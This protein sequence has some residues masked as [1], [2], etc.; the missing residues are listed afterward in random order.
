MR[1]KIKHWFTLVEI[2][3]VVS[4]LSILSTIAFVN[5]SSYTVWSRDFK[6]LWDI[7]SIKSSL[8]TYTKNNLWQ[9]P[10]VSSVSLWLDINS[11]A[12]NLAKQSYFDEEIAWKIGITKL[13]IDPKTNNRYI[14]SVTS[15]KTRY[16]ITATLEDR[17]TKIAFS[18]NTYAA[19]CTDSQKAY[20][21]WNY[22]YQSWSNLPG[23]IYAV[24]MTNPRII[25]DIN[26]NSWKVVLNWQ[27]LNVAYDMNSTPQSCATNLNQ[28]ILASTTIKGTQN[29]L[30]KNS[31]L[32]SWWISVP[33]GS[34]DAQA[35]TGTSQYGWQY[36]TCNDWSWTPGSWYNYSCK[37]I[38]WAI[39]TAD[40]KFTGCQPNY[41]QVP[42]L[43]QCKSN[44]ASTLLLAYP[45]NWAYNLPNSITF[46]WYPPVWYTGSY[47]FYLW[48]ANGVWDVDDATVLGSTQI[49]KTS[50]SL[51]TNYSWKVTDNNWVV[52]SEVRTF[53][54][55]PDL[56]AGGGW[57]IIVWTWASSNPY[58]PP[59][60]VCSTNSWSVS[61]SFIWCSNSTNPSTCWPDKPT[62]W[63]DSF[64]T[65]PRDW[66]N[67]YWKE[68]LL[69]YKIANSSDWQA[70]FKVRLQGL[71]L[72]NSESTP[73]Y[74]ET[75]SYIRDT[76]ISDWYDN[77]FSDR[78]IDLWKE[79]ITSNLYWDL[80]QWQNSSGWNSCWYDATGWYYVVNAKADCYITV[81]GRPDANVSWAWEVDVAKFLIDNVIRDATTSS[82]KHNWWTERVL[83]MRSSWFD[84]TSL[85]SMTFSTGS[86][87]AWEPANDIS[88]DNF[89]TS[90]RIDPLPKIDW[91]GYWKSMTYTLSNTNTTT[92]YFK[93]MIGWWTWTLAKPL[94]WTLPNTWADPE[95]TWSFLYTNPTVL[96]IWTTG[97][98]VWNIY[99]KNGDLAWANA[100][101]TSP[102]GTNIGK[103]Y[104]I[105]WSS[106]CK[107]TM[108][109]RSEVSIWTTFDNALMRLQ[110]RAQ[111]KSNYTYTD[112]YIYGRANWWNFT[113]N[114]Y[115]QSEILWWIKLNV[116]VTWY[117]S[118]WYAESENTWWICFDA[119][120]W[121]QITRNPTTWQLTWY[122]LSEAF[123]WIDVSQIFL[124]NANN[125]I[126]WYAASESA[127]WLF[128]WP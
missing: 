77:W 3:V 108:Y 97:N 112:R 120:C 34:N 61:V 30:S 91:Y 12:T 37:N 113:F 70:K 84:T 10:D 94:K 16:Q 122:A 86:K 17:S 126:S 95:N 13:P 114:N 96:D 64:W 47:K 80:W 24:T 56:T 2:A 85:I 67:Y 40:C 68:W 90:T 11:W 75:T 107:I 128:F 44:Q 106:S 99:R 1:T 88:S 23:L 60:I 69:S 25:I 51:G 63:K 89:W 4:I 33:H 101:A 27:N 55:M 118:Y 18:N 115:I 79:W 78:V 41:T 45:G 21:E 117:N 15:D 9:L 58:C 31:C 100:C 125:D 14:Y 98:N 38:E 72:N 62:S 76:L 8:N 103:W 81:H 87:Q 42:W 119:T 52:I 53:T 82:W 46:S 36:R 22:L 104:I 57:T 35:L 124:R 92:T 28:V 74:T 127:W 105:P 32:T 93:M 39:F 19:T 49:S 66:N 48:S 123:W 7:A 29:I 43:D 26:T 109:F 6:R 50:L 65:L 83:S 59:W 73:D 5:Y 110:L 121:A 116:N 111:P 54:T 71:K 20:V 102:T